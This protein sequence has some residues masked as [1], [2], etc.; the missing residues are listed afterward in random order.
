[1]RG[2]SPDPVNARQIKTNER[3][4][5]SWL[6]ESCPVCRTNAGQQFILDY[7]GEDA[8]AREELKEY[9]EHQKGDEPFRCQCGAKLVASIRV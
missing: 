8:L 7:A 9:K 2:G 4:P 3:L 5:V 1:M 6:V